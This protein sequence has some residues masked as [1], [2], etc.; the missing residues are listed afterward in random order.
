MFEK[1][2]V[3]RYGQTGICRIEDITPLK[4]TGA[5]QEY[6][7]L[8]PLFKA[9]ALLYVPCENA[10]LVG[11]MLPPLTPEQI[12][13]ALS[14]VRERKAE[15]TRDFRRRSEESKRA[16]GSGD[17]RDALYLIKNIY[18]RKREIL[19]EGKRIHTTD[20]YFLRDAENL[21][22]NEIAYVLEKDYEYARALVL[23]ALELE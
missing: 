16:L 20:D 2:T 23:K 21:L 13:E 6:Y 11:R 14:D 18:L 4:L 3:V 7:I 19:G 10:D 9:G 15:W 22:Y 17:R 12:R 8:M 1:G 5:E